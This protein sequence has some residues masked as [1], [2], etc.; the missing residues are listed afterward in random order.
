MKVNQ[1]PELDVR[2]VSFPSSP[3]YVTF[4]VNGQGY[5]YGIIAVL[6]GAIEFAEYINLLQTKSAEIYFIKRATLVR[7]ITGEPVKLYIIQFNEVFA[8][9]TLYNLHSSTLD[10][11][12]SADISRITAD[13]YNFKIIKKLLLL[14]YKHNGS[15]ASPNTLLIRQLTFNLLLSCISELKDLLV[16][17]LQP[18]AKYKIA[19]A[20]RFFRLVEEHALEQHGVKFYA[21]SL[22]MTQGNLTRIIKEVT[23]K[24]PKSIIEEFLI[25]KAE[26]MLDNN[27]LTVYT[28]AEEL[29]FKSSSAFIN[30]FRLHSGRTPNEY[31]NR[32]FRDL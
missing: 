15:A 31:R 16:P 8:Q 12:F 13:R 26:M 18:A 6:E 5:R 11:I 2:L 28:V 7:A 25:Q 27:L 1:L 29:G 32:K 23:A 22:C 4:L 10:R 9:N 30:F 17:L 19:M 14:L 21:A 20:I 3:V 24:L